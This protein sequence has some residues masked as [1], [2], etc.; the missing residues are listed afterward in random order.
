MAV[1]RCCR[2]ACDLLRA[3]TARS[4]LRHCPKETNELD[5]LEQWCAIFFTLERRYRILKPCY[6]SL[7]AATSWRPLALLMLRPS[8]APQFALNCRH[9]TTKLVRSGGGNTKS[10]THGRISQRHAVWV[11]LVFFKRVSYFA[12][13]KR[14]FFLNFFLPTL[15]ALDIAC[16][17]QASRNALRASVSF[18]FFC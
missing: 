14:L 1:Q 4:C 3:A 6:T 7:C 18:F 16:L 17:E 2:T 13:L 12:Y 11:F 9:G 5:L 8:S 15:K 10:K